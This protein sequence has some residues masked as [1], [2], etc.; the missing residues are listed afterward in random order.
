MKLFAAAAVLSVAVAVG[1]AAASAEPSDDP[2]S[3]FAPASA[4][5]RG[6][7]RADP[8]APTLFDTSP[9]SNKSTKSSKK[10]GLK[11]QPQTCSLEPGNLCSPNLGL[12]NPVDMRTCLEQNITQPDADLIWLDHKSE[13]LPG[14]ER[15]N[16]VVKKLTFPEDNYAEF[17]QAR[18]S[19]GTGGPR[20]PAGIVYAETVDDVLTAVECARESGVQVSPRGRGHSYQ[21]LSNMDG[22]FVIDMSLMCNPNNDTRDDVFTIDTTL[23]GTAWLLG[24]DQKVLGTIKAGAGCT[25]AVMLAYTATADEFKDDKGG[26]FVIGSCPSVGIIGYAVGGGQG[27]MTPYV[28]VGVDDAKSYN[29]VIYN[30]TSGKAEEVTASNLSHPDLYWYL[31]GSGGGI[32]VVTAVEKAVIASPEPVEDKRK[33]TRFRLIYDDIAGN[34]ALIA[35]FIEGIQDFVIPDEKDPKKYK[36]RV[37]ENSRF[38]AQALLGGFTGGQFNLRGVWLGSKAELN[39]TLSKYHL[40]DNDILN[41][42]DNQ[43]FDSYGRAEASHL[44]SEINLDLPITGSWWPLWTA[45][46][47]GSNP[48]QGDDFYNICAE[49]GLTNDFCDPRAIV[50]LDGTTLPTTAY[51]PKCDDLT[52]LDQMVKVATNPASFLNRPGQEI[53]LLRY[54]PQ[55]LNGTR[56]PIQSESGGLMLPRLKTETWLKIAKVGVTI[57]HFAHGAPTLVERAATAYAN[58]EEVFLVQCTSTDQYAQ[59]AEILT[60]DHYNVRI[61]IFRSYTLCWLIQKLNC[62]P[63]HRV[64]VPNCEASTTI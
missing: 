54:L 28:G 24:E 57:N 9:K 7:E 15:E 37:Q 50:A 11:P 59:V 5:V 20:V 14:A 55:I 38:G 64:T 58:R 21:G 43:E 23:A 17:A 61:E 2:R 27:E 29:I 44:C 31:R 1:S 41:E 33:F 47:L 56:G 18:L 4:A 35:K 60:N 30:E 19:A 45:P 34:D 26:I 53:F 46:T 16:I 62:F 39:A 42:V 13:G 36:A 51:V 25:N 12:R 40:L 10:G 8:A 48:F 52:V 22:F 3:L 32:G 49:L 6:G 63:Q